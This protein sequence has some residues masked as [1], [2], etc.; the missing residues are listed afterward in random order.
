M[1]EIQA[2]KALGFDAAHRKQVRDYSRSRGATISSF[3]KVAADLFIL[4]AN[5]DRRR[6]EQRRAAALIGEEKYVR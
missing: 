5:E 4:Q 2:L 6:R 1:S 3:L